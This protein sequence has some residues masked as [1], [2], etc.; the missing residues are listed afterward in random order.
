L[1]NPTGAVLVSFEQILQ[2]AGG[3]VCGRL[4]G[5]E[6]EDDEEG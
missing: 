1:A 2:E 5:T 6:E 4:R 3:A